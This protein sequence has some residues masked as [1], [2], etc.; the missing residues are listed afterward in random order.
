MSKNKLQRYEEVRLLENVFEY[1]DFQNPGKTTPKGEWREKVFRNPRPILLELA[2]GKGDYA[3]NLAKKFPDQNFVGV[4][5]KGARLWKGATRAKEQGIDNLR[6]LR[7]FIDH[8]DQYF[9][10]GEVDEIWI[11]FPDPYP[12]S[13]RE[14]KRLTSPRFLEL[15]RKVLKNGGDIHLKTDS[16]SLFHYSL[17]TVKEE[18]GEILDR[19]DDIYRDRPGDELLSI[20]TYYEKKHLEAGKTIK[21]LRFRLAQD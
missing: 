17:S 10:A 14:K 5:I 1:T 6:F 12:K 9:A 19:V 8:L 7:I 18:K 11:T 21:Y 2:C 20:K 3:L 13:K 16:D 15:Y 4:D